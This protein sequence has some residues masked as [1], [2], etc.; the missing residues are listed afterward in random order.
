MVQLT[1]IRLTIHVSEILV[2]GIPRW[3][4]GRGSRLKFP[5]EGVGSIIPGVLPTGVVMVW[6]W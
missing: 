4:C 1:S 2:S 5:D 6:S 3:S